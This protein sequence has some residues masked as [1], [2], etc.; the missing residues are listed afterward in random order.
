MRHKRIAEG[1]G[2]IAK[3]G[4]KISDYDMGLI[5]FLRRGASEV[6][7]KEGSARVCKPLIQFDGALQRALGTNKVA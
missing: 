3:Y 6:G 1:E 5:M 4:Y 7:R 2:E